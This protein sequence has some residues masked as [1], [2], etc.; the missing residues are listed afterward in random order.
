M[1][2]SEF[3]LFCQGLTHSQMSFNDVWYVLKDSSRTC[4]I[5]SG[6]YKIYV[7]EAS[8][9]EPEAYS[10]VTDLVLR[11]SRQ[12]IFKISLP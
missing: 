9:D 6:N 7:S 11:A 10:I 12:I 4:K 2:M 8:C 1:K 5:Y 3:D